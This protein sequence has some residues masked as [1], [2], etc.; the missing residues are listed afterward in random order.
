M[1][2]NY[3]NVE[4]AATSATINEWFIPDAFSFG[5]NEA[6]LPITMFDIDFV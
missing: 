4:C 5:N 1:K 6:S 2:F 3:N